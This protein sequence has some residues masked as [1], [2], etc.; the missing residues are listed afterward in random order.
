MCSETGGRLWNQ[1]KINRIK[2]EP[3]DASSRSD[4]KRKRCTR[5][6]RRNRSPS[7]VKRIRRNR[8]VKAND[9]ERSRMHGLNDALDGLRK[10]LPHLPD[11]TK[12]TKI[13]TLRLAHNYIW[14][15]SEMLK[16]T[17][18]GD[19]MSSEFMDELHAQSFNCMD[20]PQV[21]YPCKDNF[22]TD[23][24]AYVSSNHNVCVNSS[25]VKSGLDNSVQ[26]DSYTKP[27]LAS[28]CLQTVSQNA[29]YDSA[30]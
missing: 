28:A 30:T 23:S 17:D 12:L 19:P 22:K 29:M 21:K 20:R 3:G 27:A 26:S 25:S 16:L 10:V 7:C 8:R 9:R 6:R 13:E 2:S 18:S 1:K 5:S 14:T 15:L 4:T 24:A 11:D